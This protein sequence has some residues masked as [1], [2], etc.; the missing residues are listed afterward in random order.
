MKKVNI[1]DELEVRSRN[2]QEEQKSLLEDVTLLLEESTKNDRQTLKDC[3]LGFEVHTQEQAQGEA[4]EREKFFKEYGTHVHIKDIVSL[5]RKYLLRFLPVEQYKGAVGVSVASDIRD[6]VAEHGLE[7]EQRSG[8]FKK[9]LYVLGP[10]E[11]FNLKEKPAPPR[12][13][14]P[15]LFYR[16]DKYNDSPNT[17]LYIPIAKWGE[18]FTTARRLMALAHVPLTFFI[19]L[20]ILIGTFTGIVGG[21]SAFVITTLVA[22]FLPITIYSIIY[23]FADK[24]NNMK[25]SDLWTSQFDPT[26]AYKS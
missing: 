19:T 14:E 9:C 3:G 25:Y 24:N 12:D 17:D 8:N 11:A 15:V 1:I 22:F 13:I 23:L 16:P 2:A 7:A 21:F 26:Y 5:G 4:I 18:D 6:F 10:K 20:S